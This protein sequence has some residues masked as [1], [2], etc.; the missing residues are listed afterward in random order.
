MNFQIKDS[1]VREEM[2]TG[3]LRDTRD[4]KGRYDL[5]PVRA[6]RRLAR[7]FE[8]GS[9]KYGDRNWE[10]GQP[11][12]RMMDSALRHAFTALAGETDEDHI[13]A[14]AWNL[15]CVADIQ[16]RIREGLLPESLDD[17]PKPT[18]PEWTAAPPTSDK[19][20]E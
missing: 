6:L 11:L 15:L 10:R 8:A 4:G 19:I 5:L 1:G 20:R 7:H 13:I 17:L 3:S 14:A 18:K 12:A 9:K 16:E 2:S